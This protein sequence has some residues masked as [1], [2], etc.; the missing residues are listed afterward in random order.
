MSC[1]D[2]KDQT[3]VN[4]YD[5]GGTSLQKDPIAGTESSLS[6]PDL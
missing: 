1:V 6:F 3:L 4:N 2:S 5:D